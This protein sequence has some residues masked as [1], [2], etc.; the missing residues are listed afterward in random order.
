L[1]A[2]ITHCAASTVTELKKLAAMELEPSTV[3]REEYTVL[4]ATIHQQYRYALAPDPAH[5]ASLWAI[6]A[7]I[8]LEF[9]VKNGDGIAREVAAGAI[10]AATRKSLIDRCATSVQLGHESNSE[11]K[12][13]DNA[14]E[15]MSS[16]QAYLERRCCAPTSTVLNSLFDSGVE[17]FR[18]CRG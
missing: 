4:R 8:F 3:L 5:E 15:V 9:L 12:D 14:L 10:S 17:A 6:A 11:E 7:D 2:N 16:A 13:R 18:R 1:E